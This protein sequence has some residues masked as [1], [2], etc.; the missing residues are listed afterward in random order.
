VLNAANELAVAWFLE[1]RIGFTAIPQVIEQTMDA[2]V[3]AEVSTIAAVRAV[4]SWA[5]VQAQEMARR[6]QSKLEG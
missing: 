2:H 3:P 4:D 5:R 1:G 6:L